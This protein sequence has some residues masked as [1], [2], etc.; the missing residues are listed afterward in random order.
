MGGN[1]AVLVTAIMLAKRLNAKLVV[2]WEEGVYGVADRDIFQHLFDYPLNDISLKY[3]DGAKVWPPAWQEFYKKTMP[4]RVVGGVN[5]SN[6]STDLAKEFG[7]NNLKEKFNTVIISRD[8]SWW[9][10]PEFKEESEH[11]VR[12]LKPSA[13]I[14]A[15]INKYELGDNAIAVHF[16]HGNGE[17]TVVPPDINWFFSQVDSFIRQSPTSK[18]L[19]CTDCLRV[20]HKFQ[21]RYGDKVISTDK[22]YLGLGK[23]AMHCNESEIDRLYSAEEAIVDIWSM[24]R[25]KY[26]VGSKSFFTGVALKLASAARQNIKVWSPIHRSHRQEPDKV[27][28]SDDPWARECFF[29]AG[30]YTDG[31]FI[32]FLERGVSFYY[33]YDELASFDSLENIDLGAVQA[34]LNIKRLY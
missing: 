19:V 14:L 33:L 11:V 32:K 10:W 25:C 4:Y 15:R 30:M 9:H 8:S 31:V 27:P 21:E 2:D 22:S 34:E 20:L 13:H 29:K 5:L 23:G 1:I 7:I 17:P 26:F 6:I 3:D 24:G 12:S 28:V 16:R 18:V